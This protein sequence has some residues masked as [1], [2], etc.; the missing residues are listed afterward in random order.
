MMLTTSGWSFAAC[1]SSTGGYAQVA[2][3]CASRGASGP[4]SSSSGFMPM[5]M[6][7]AP[8]ARE[9]RHVTRGR[10]GEAPRRAARAEP[11]PRLQRKVQ[12]E[13]ERKRAAA[14]GARRV[15]RQVPPAVLRQD[16]P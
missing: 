3:V 2:L 8:C 7:P 12:R 16:G 14:R 5:T 15:P 9:S 1:I 4:S 11:R 6:L 13:D 10:A